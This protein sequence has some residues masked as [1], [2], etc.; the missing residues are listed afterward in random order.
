MKAAFVRIIVIASF[1]FGLV[2]PRSFAQQQGQAQRGPS[3][4]EERTRA[5]K[6]AHQLEDDPLSKNA[7]D[8]RAWMVQWIIEIPDITIDVCSDYFGDLPNPP[9]HHST[10]IFTQMSLSSAAFIVEHPD[11]AKDEQ[12]VALAGLLG[13]LKSYESILKQEPASHW[14]EVDKLLKVRDV[15]KLDD[16]VAETLIKCKKDNEDDPPPGT[17]RT[18]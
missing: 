5:V 3:T 15:G 10:E 13:S 9:R 8:D 12:A 6:V 7:D 14:P 2:T 18:L 16:F 1:I 4:P 11:K 17:V